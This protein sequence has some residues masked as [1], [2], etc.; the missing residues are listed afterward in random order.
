MSIHHNICLH[1]TCSWQHL[2]NLILFADDDNG[3]NV[4][5]FVKK[6]ASAVK[7]AQTLLAEG[8][9]EERVKHPGKQL[10]YNLF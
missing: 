1:R 2:N 3:N 10:F 6:T 7:Q 5:L 4:E 8:G 9:I